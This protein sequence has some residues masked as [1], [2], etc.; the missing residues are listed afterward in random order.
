M[1]FTAINYITSPG[2]ILLA[3]DQDRN[4]E[5]EEEKNRLITQ[6]LELQNTLDGK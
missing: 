4:P 1:Q 5:E 6:I 3:D 2:Y